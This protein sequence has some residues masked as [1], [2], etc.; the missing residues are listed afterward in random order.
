M[1]REKTMNLFE[2]DFY[3]TR[4][5]LAI[6]VPFGTGETV[7]KNR[8]SH[9]FAFFAD[10]VYSYAF[11]NMKAITCRKGDVIYMPQGSSYAV[12]Q[13]SH[14]DGAAK[15]VFAINFLISSDERFEPFRMSPKNPAKIGALFESA[16]RTWVKK[17]PGCLDAVFSHLYGIISLLKKE[18]HSSYYD[19]K[20]KALISPAIDYIGNHYTFEKISVEKLAVLCGISVSYLRRLFG[21][22]YGVSPVEYI[23]SL[24]LAYA[25][26]LLCSGEFS[27]TA[28]A[29]HAGFND[30][31]YFSRTFKAH[32]GM[33]PAN[34][35]KNQ[36]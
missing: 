1:W 13:Q 5:T 27:V 19:S 4:P 20:Y 15:S 25:R 16:E 24:R 7:H 30:I 11:E 23:T 18:Y 36:Q 10:G 32:F 35:I 22:C 8:P 17:D 28:A 9:G 29:E 12:T 31:S 21:C 33:S 3:V 14:T 6:H 34:L 26:E 2:T